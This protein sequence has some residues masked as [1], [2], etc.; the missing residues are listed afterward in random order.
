[1]AFLRMLIHPVKWWIEKID[2]GELSISCGYE[3]DGR[4]EQVILEIRSRR[5]SLWR[6][7]YF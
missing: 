2:D 7:K 6:E 1:M 5:I 4:K 3:K